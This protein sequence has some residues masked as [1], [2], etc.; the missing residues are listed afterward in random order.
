MK[1][2][3]LSFLFFVILSA[4]S[5]TTTHYYLVRHAER[6]DSSADSPLSPAGHTR[7]IALKDVLLAKNID[8]ILV[9]NRLRTQQTA[10]PLAEALHIRPTIYSPDTTAGLT[11]AL[12]LIA[13]KKVLVVGHSNT[14][15]EI[16]L[17]LSGQTVQIADNDFDNLFIVSKRRFMGHTSIRFE[18]HTYGAPSP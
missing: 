14:I 7:A 10:Q 13:G 5:C 17:G 11:Q 6:L 15:P 18:H 4:T 16:V 2:K 1:F 8:T 9:S 3:P 12:R